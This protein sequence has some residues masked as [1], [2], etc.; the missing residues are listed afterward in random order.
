[1]NERN[2][3]Y[4]RVL[5]S[6]RHPGCRRHRIVVVVGGDDHDPDGELESCKGRRDLPLLLLSSQQRWQ[7]PREK[8][9]EE[10]E[11]ED[12]MRSPSLPS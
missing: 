5:S 6:F 4:H 11:E 7:I 12:I 8:E 10:E 9:E 3:Q 1:M 2:T